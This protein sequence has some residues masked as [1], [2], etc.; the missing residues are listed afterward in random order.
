MQMWRTQ[1]YKKFKKIWQKFVVKAKL[2]KDLYFYKQY[3]INVKI[4]FLLKSGEM[5]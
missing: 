5:L 3:I 2:W 4:H 1:R